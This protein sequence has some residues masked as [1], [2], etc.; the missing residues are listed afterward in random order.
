MSSL[1]VSLS[2][3]RGLTRQ[4]LSDL[5]RFAGRR[6]RED[7]LPQVAGSLT[8]TTILSLVPM[9]TIALALFT[10]FPLFSTFRASLEAYFVD[11]LMPKGV[12]N[13]ILGYLN[14]FAAKS[15]RISAVGGVLLILTSVL[16][17]STIESVF[18][19]I[20]RVKKSRPLVQ[21]VLVYWAIITL[22]PLL[23]GVS[24][25]VTS[26]LSTATGG[27]VKSLP[28]LGASFYTL[29]SLMF[30]TLA[31]TLLYSTVPNQTVDWRDAAAGGLLAGIGLEIAK[32]LFAAYILKFP[33]YTMVYGTVAVLPIFLVWIYMMW[34]VTLFGALLTAALP[35][36]RYERWW[37]VPSPG[38]EFIDA[39]KVLKF[40]HAARVG[41]DSAVVS[42]EEVRRA[43]KLGLGEL[44]QLLA[45]MSEEGWVAS[46]KPD[47]RARS[48][49][50]RRITDDMDRWTLAANPGTIQLARVYRLFVFDPAVLAQAGEEETLVTRVEEAINAV[51][52][53]SLEE[54]CQG[55]RADDQAV[56]EAAAAVTAMPYAAVPLEQRRRMWER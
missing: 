35:V 41:V 45:R 17:M 34:M 24:I 30:S 21:R 39:V 46:V 1:R 11:N 6:L 32:R 31:Y 56:Q 2:R 9:L 37:H 20:W 50:N 25:S 47:T 42:M 49:W 44:Q 48:G 27:A 12:A 55:G 51:L 7:R 38:A 43:T 14:Q 26:Y 8:F 3:M 54:Y 52:A 29:V 15:A 13:T 10:A 33:T 18:N 4:Q 36:V 40:L 16:T 22:G 53:Q 28:W 19:Q 23:I 5:L